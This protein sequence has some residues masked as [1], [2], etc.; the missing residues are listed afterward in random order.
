MLIFIGVLLTSSAILSNISVETQ[1]KRR[2]KTAPE[3]AREYSIGRRVRYPRV[4]KSLWKVEMKVVERTEYIDYLLVPVRNH[5]DKRVV[6]ALINAAGL[7]HANRDYIV[8]DRAL[9]K[10]APHQFPEDLIPEAKIE[11]HAIGIYTQDEYKIWV[12][13]AYPDTS[14]IVG[15][16]TEALKD[17]FEYTLIFIPDSEDSY[18]YFYVGFVWTGPDLYP[19]VFVEVVVDYMNGDSG[20]FWY[21]CNLITFDIKL[22][23]PGVTPNLDP[24]M[25]LVERSIT[26]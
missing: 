9:V 2:F 25:K 19:R 18:R 5:H 6:A 22:L 23:S 12:A 14:M 17:S 21:E 16:F 15:S 20:V 11:V 26:G 1:G 3:L 10:P 24:G 4:D 8:F 13:R 7:H